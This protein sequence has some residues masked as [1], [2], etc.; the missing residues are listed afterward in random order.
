[1]PTPASGTI[2]MLNMRS[3]ITRGGGAISMSE[4]RT[5][6][7]RSGA[8]SFNQMYD[9]EGWVQTNGQ[10]VTKFVTINGWHYQFGPTGSVSPN[11]TGDNR[12]IIIST[13]NGSRIFSNHQVSG[14]AC[15]QLSFQNT[16]QGSTLSSGY[17]PTNVTR[18]VAGNTARTLGGTTSSIRYWTGLTMPT[19][20]S[21]H[22]MVQ[23]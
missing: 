18:I 2:S 8:I 5:R 9:C 23:F 1:M 3:E 12:L 21:L 4:V 22:C 19:G 15:N 10:T 20:G 13:G 7:G 6:A 16:T 17:A 11:E 14:Q